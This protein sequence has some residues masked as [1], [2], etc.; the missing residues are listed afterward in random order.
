MKKLPW[1]LALSLLMAT[2]T[3]SASAGSPE[4]AQ[5]LHCIEQVEQT[6]ASGLREAE[7]EAGLFTRMK[8]R[9]V[10]RRARLEGR[11]A[12]SR[13]ITE[14]RAEQMLSEMTGRLDARL[15][16]GRPNNGS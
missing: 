15:A 5:L 6:Y 1:L 14:Q 11:E 8:S 16:A 2:A 7:S 4:R 13:Q 12:C 10:A 9:M 3:Q